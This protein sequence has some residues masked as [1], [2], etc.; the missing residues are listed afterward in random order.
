M[1]SQMM[2]QKLKESQARGDHVVILSSSPDFLVKEIAYRLQVLH[3][4]ATDY[5]CSEDGTMMAISQVMEG[6]DK[7]NY[8]QRIAHEMGIVQANI[9]VYS[10]SYLDLPILKIAGRAIAVDPDAYLRKACLQNGW[11]ILLSKDAKNI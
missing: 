1:Q 6:Q 2:I 5:Q 9:T 10:D 7:A 11:E 8:I 4:R 3:C